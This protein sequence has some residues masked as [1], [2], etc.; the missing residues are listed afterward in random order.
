MLR[1]KPSRNVDNLAEALIVDNGGPEEVREDTQNHGRIVS[2]VAAPQLLRKGSIG[3]APCHAT[4]EILAGS[5][6]GG[7]SS[8]QMLQHAPDGLIQSTCA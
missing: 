4:V 8:S 5:L 6:R 3:A 7:S 2:L 1:V